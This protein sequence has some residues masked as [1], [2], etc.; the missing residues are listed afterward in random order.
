MNVID[1]ILIIPLLW[2]IYKGFRDG[3]AVQLGGVAGLFIGIYLA[4]RFGPAVGELLKIDPEFAPAAGFAIIVVAVI[5]AIAIIGRIM[6]K[7][8]RFAGL[9]VLDQIGGALL[10]LLK[11][12]LIVGLL[13]YGFNHINRSQQWVKQARLDNSLLF[14][15]LS[16]AAATT[17]PYINSAKDKFFPQTDRQDEAG[18]AETDQTANDGQ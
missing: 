2:S 17:F 10:S 1:I 14:N 3:I 4:F 18:E 16:K 7:L 5:I 6:R 12:G 11:V 9:G 13:A 8:F 15:T